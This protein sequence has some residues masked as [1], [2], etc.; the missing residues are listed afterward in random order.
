MHLSSNNL[1]IIYILLKNYVFII[2]MTSVTVCIMSDFNILVFA[3]I[4]LLKFSNLLHIVTIFT[5]H[6]HINTSVTCML[7]FFN[8]VDFTFPPVYI[9]TCHDEVYQFSVTIAEKG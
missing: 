1:E 2:F 6:F 5:H 4:G 9:S 7:L 3:C 8:Q